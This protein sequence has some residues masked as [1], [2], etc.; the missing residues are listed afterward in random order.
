MAA[1]LPD[2]P[3]NDIVGTNSGPVFAGKIEVSKRLL[4]HRLSLGTR[5]GGEQIAVKVDGAPL[6]SGLREH[7]SH[8]LRHT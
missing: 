7:L 8:S 5:R 6:V 3:F 2:E 1:N 4:R